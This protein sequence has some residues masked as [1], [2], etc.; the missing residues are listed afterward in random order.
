MID[1]V[2]RAWGVPIR[3]AVAG[4]AGFALAWAA[5]PSASASEAAAFEVGKSYGH[6]IEY[7]PGNAPVEVALV[8]S[9]GTGPRA[10]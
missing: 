3:M 8:V 5:V 1:R 10:S 2:R 4:A 9:V 7:L 6:Y